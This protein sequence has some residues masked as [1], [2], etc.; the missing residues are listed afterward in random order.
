MK[1]NKAIILGISLMAL[2]IHMA[3]GQP[4][5]PPPPPPRGQPYGSVGVPNQP[6]KQPKPMN[7]T[8][9]REEYKRLSTERGKVEKQ[10]GQIMQDVGKAKERVNESST[11]VGK[12]F[13]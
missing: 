11:P 12:W 3:W 9:I 2:V 10:V 13:A 4:M 5:N 6:M 8:K 1:Q 7:P